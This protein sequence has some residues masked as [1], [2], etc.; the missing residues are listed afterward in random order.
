MR[1]VPAR[2]TQHALAAGEIG[3]TVGSERHRACGAAWRRGGGRT[4]GGAWPGTRTVSTH[5]SPG[6]AAC[7]VDQAPPVPFR[8]TLWHPR[9]SS[10]EKLSLAQYSE[11]NSATRAT[12]HK[13]IDV[14][15]RPRK[16]LLH[17][18]IRL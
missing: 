5:P 17:T 10:W 13:R 2:R 18:P 3:L 14:R 16:E 8:W 15:E 6:P 1:G 4:A 12:I 7:A 9:T 11:N